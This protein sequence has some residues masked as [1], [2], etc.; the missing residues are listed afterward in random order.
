[1]F[2]VLNCTM[3][4]CSIYIL[5]LTDLRIIK[6]TSDKKVT[7]SSMYCT[8]TNTDCNDVLSLLHQLYYILQTMHNA[9]S[10]LHIRKGNE[11]EFTQSYRKANLIEFS[12][13]HHHNMDKIIQLYNKYETIHCCNYHNSFFINA[14]NTVCSYQYRR[15]RR[16]SLS[17]TLARTLQLTCNDYVK[18]SPD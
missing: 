9:K 8:Y 4:N 11:S 15:A 13:F 14:N 3:N 5:L 1:M 2:Q 16:P 17:L 10:T 6:H 7:N 12:T 18:A